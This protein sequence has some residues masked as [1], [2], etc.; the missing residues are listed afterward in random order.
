MQQHLQLQT[1]LLI[2]LHLLK[3]LLLARLLR[4]LLVWIL[5]QAVL[6]TTQ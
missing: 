4:S 2:Q 3:Q 5:K 1:Q 6:A